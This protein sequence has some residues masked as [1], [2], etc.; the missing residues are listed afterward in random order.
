[1]VTTDAQDLPDPSSDP[2]A[3]PPDGPSAA[4]AGGLPQALL[5]DMD[6]T[7]VDTEPYWFAAEHALVAEHG[8]RWSDE[9]AL[10]LVG[11]ELMAAAAVLQ[12]RGGVRMEARA[13]V[14]HLVA[15]V[16]ARVAQ[17]IPWRPGARELL[18]GAVA[19]GV[20]CALVTMSWAPVTTALIGALPAGTF[21]AVVTGDVVTRGKPHPEPYLTAA[22]L[23]GVDPA[24]CLALE[25]S[26]PGVT[27]ALAAGV[28]TIGVPHTVALPGGPGSAEPAPPGLTVLTTLRGVDLAGLV[29]AA[30]GTARRASR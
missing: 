8:D 5:W 27:S 12:E 14:E 3:A 21:S 18:A 17:E 6:G 30:A 16:S 20:P 26:V 24:R 7:I 22:R 13:I 1:V 15:D 4:A 10:A 2:S 11:S 23:L 28:P 25:D 19:A 29:E 9:D